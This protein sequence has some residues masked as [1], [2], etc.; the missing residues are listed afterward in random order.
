MLLG[1]MKEILCNISFCN[2]YK[3]QSPIVA[4]S[5][6][7]FKCH[8]CDAGVPLT[9]ENFQSIIRWDWKINGDVFY[10][11]LLVSNKQ[12]QTNWFEKIKR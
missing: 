9:S 1:S 12:N 6:L 10:E 7:F 5:E 2:G 4:E 11:V 3:C 8:F